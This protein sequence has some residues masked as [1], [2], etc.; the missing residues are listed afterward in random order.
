MAY[1]SAFMSAREAA[2]VEA[3]TGGVVELVKDGKLT[4]EGIRRGIK[5]PT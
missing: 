4:E 1:R 2:K 5:L 3:L